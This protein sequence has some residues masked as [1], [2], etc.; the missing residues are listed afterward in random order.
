MDKRKDIIKKAAAAALIA[1]IAAFF[2]TDAVRAKQFGLPPL[3]CVKAVT[4]G[5]GFSA[6]YYGAGYKIKRDHDITDGSDEYYITLWL[7]PDSVSL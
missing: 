5:D 4:Y 2:I 7:L 6:D 3:F 1:V